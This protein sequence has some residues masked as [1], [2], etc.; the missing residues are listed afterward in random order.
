MLN[1]FKQ[2]NRKIL[3]SCCSIKTFN[4]GILC[5]LPL[6]ETVQC[7]L[8]FGRPFHKL[9][10]NKF[11]SIITVKC[12]WLTAPFDDLLQRPD[13]SLCKQRDV[14]IYGQ[15]LVAKDV[16]HIECAYRVVIFERIVHK[17]HRP[18]L[19]NIRWHA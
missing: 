1:V 16:K 10:T 6:L 14:H 9:M 2:V 7:Y 15:A 5:W 11:G 18:H 3:L 13:N 8:L 19:I 4:I 17:T 12:A